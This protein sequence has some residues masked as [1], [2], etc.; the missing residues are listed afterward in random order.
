MG[1]TN[2]ITFFFFFFFFFNLN[3]N[4]N[5]HKSITGNQKRDIFILSNEK[6][7][8]LENR[9]QVEKEFADQADLES[10][11]SNKDKDVEQD[12]RGLYMK[13]QKRRNKKQY[14]NNTEG[15]LELLL[16]RYLR[17]QLRW[18]DSS[19]QRILNNIK[20]YCLLLRLINPIENA[21]SAFQR[22]EMSLDIL[23]VHK[24]LTYTELK[25]RGIFIIE[26]IRMII[27]M[28]GQFLIYQ[29]ENSNLFQF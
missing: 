2:Q 10:A 11:L 4:V 25:K 14:K 3:E 1:H 26:P 24:D 12:F 6:A 5:K 7:L 28:D 29:I 9:N 18:D 22:E 27:K 15:E 16:K 8:E 13:K 20:V 17:F 19:N 21:I 23:M